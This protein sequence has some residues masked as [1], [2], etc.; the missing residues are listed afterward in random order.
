MESCDSVE[1]GSS[2]N[3][4]FRTFCFWLLSYLWAGWAGSGRLA[5][6]CPR[7]PQACREADLRDKLFLGL[8]PLVWGPVR[9][10]A[11]DLARGV[12][13]GE[14]FPVLSAASAQP[15]PETLARLQHAYTLRE[16]FDPAWAA[17]PLKL[18]PHRG[19]LTLL[20][21]DPGGEPL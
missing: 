11:G 15:S 13:D 19:R 17:R 1:L 18:E 7:R 9:M 2:S 3:V 6:S 10:E 14:P 12:W 8:R 5:R 20:I 4:R 21:V 16:E